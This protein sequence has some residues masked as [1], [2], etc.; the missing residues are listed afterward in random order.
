LIGVLRVCCLILLFLA[1]VIKMNTIL[2][3]EHVN[4][5]LENDIFA[6]WRKLVGM[7]E[8]GGG[9]IARFTWSC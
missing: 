4:S 3:P 9:V 1:G 7:T 5:K 8:V 2:P 6:E